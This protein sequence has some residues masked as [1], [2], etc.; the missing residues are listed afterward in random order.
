MSR[1]FSTLTGDCCSQSYV[2]VKR[3]RCDPGSSEGSVNRTS[4]FTPIWNQRPNNPFKG[5]SHHLV[6]TYVTSFLWSWG[7]AY[8]VLVVYPSDSCSPYPNEQPFV[9][10]GV[11]TS[12]LIIDQMLVRPA[13][14]PTIH[15]HTRPSIRVCFQWPLPDSS[16][17]LISKDKV[18]WNLTRL[19]LLPPPDTSH[20][21]RVRTIQ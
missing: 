15:T 3:D 1:S 9:F 20:W 2:H 19:I 6:M 17:P 4:L 16:D 10:Y 5:I 14:I 11:H 13:A 21:V 8:P 7:I 12:S 18:C